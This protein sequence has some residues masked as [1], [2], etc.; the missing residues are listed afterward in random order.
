MQIY[1]EGETKNTNG[2]Y[3]S[4]ENNGIGEAALDRY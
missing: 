4:V 1:L 3:W 2:L